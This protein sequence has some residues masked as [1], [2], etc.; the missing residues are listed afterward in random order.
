M[1]FKCQFI[2]GCKEKQEIPRRTTVSAKFILNPLI[3]NIFKMIRF[4]KE[5]YT[6]N[7]SVLL[8]MN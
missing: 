2:V 5:Q 8:S 3:L 7:Y 4:W 6:D 1:S